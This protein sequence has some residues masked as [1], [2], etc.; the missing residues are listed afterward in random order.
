[1]FNLQ[2]WFGGDSS[3]RETAHAW[4]KRGA[5]LLDVRT[6]EEFASGHVNGAL[7][8]P[9]QELAHRTQELSGADRSIVVY[10]RSGGR[11]ASAAQLLRRQGYAVHDLGPMSAW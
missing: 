10:C 11:S 5:L 6:R 1:M 7:N 9:L 4:V 3:N 2:S 8:I